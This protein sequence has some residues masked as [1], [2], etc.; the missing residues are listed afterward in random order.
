MSF[1]SLSSPFTVLQIWPTVRSQRA[2]LR[3]AHWSPVPSVHAP[4]RPP[5]RWEDDGHGERRGV[6]DS[7]SW[8]RAR[9]DRSE[10]HALAASW[11]FSRP[12]IKQT[13]VDPEEGCCS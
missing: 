2:L 11:T 1:A 13:P 4:G 3:E 10:K 6:A 7:F 5:R 8:L 9:P 12:A